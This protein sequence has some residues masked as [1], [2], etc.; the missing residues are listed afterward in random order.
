MHL[1][2][3][4]NEP[5]LKGQCIGYYGCKVT[6]VPDHQKNWKIVVSTRYLDRI[7]TTGLSAELQLSQRES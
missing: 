1:N 4:L 6:V 2:R 5:F 3:H 7:N